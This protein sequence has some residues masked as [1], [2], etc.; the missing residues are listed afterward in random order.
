M[1]TNGEKAEVAI[2]IYR[3]LWGF[4]NENVSMRRNA[5]DLSARLHSA[6]KKMRRAK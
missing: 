5:N 2:L 3:N 1:E 4:R 6:K